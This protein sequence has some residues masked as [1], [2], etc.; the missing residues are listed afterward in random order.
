MP[1]TAPR[2]DF[3]AV[4]NSA[5]GSYLLL[6]PDLTIVAVD[7]AY[8]AA[9]MTSREAIVGRAL[10]DVFPDDPNDPAA[11]GERNL[12]ASLEGAGVPTAASR[13]ATGA[14]SIRRCS[15]P[16]AKSAT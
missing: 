9:T 5:P 3:E 8:L 16:T 2:A 12:R 11:T 15:G 6:A 1:D 4:F 14:R 10:F 13:C 7:D